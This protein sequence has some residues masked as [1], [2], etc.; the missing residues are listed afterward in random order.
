MC[1]V[2]S[3]GLFFDLAQQRGPGARRV[4]AA[5]EMFV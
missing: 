2:S 1:G 5:H 4:D 3:A